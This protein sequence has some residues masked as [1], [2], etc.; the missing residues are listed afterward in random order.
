MVPDLIGRVT[1][2]RTVGRG[3]LRRGSAERAVYRSNAQLVSIIY[4]RVLPRAV[5]SGC[6][7]RIN[8]LMQRPGGGR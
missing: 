4:G 2:L 3:A 1:Y 7:P 6:A 5:R 8:T